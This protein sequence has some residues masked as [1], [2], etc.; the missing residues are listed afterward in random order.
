MDHS[1]STS[2]RKGL[3]VA[4]LVILGLLVAANNGFGFSTEALDR[5][6]AAWSD[7][8][9][10]SMEEEVLSL[11]DYLALEDQ[12]RLTAQAL[13]EV[14]P[15]RAQLNRSQ[16]EQLNGID[17]ISQ[18]VQSEN[19]WP[20]GLQQARDQGQTAAKNVDKAMEK[21]N[22]KRKK[23]STDNDNPSDDSDNQDGDADQAQGNNGRK[24]HR[25]VRRPGGHSKYGYLADFDRALDTMKTELLALNIPHSQW[26]LHKKSGRLD[27]DQRYINTIINHTPSYSEALTVF[28]QRLSALAETEAELDTKALYGELML[29]HIYLRPDHG[30]RVVDLGLRGQQKAYGS[31]ADQ[32]FAARA[33]LALNSADQSSVDGH[34][35]NLPQ[36]LNEQNPIFLEL[37]SALAALLHKYQSQFSGF[38]GSHYKLASAVAFV[39]IINDLASYEEAQPTAT[40]LAASLTDLTTLWDYRSCW[41]MQARGSDRQSICHDQLAPQITPTTQTLIEK[42][43]LR[44]RTSE[45]VKHHSYV[46]QQLFYGASSLHTLLD[47]PVRIHQQTILKGEL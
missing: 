12:K 33:N 43:V 4:A 8:T 21:I 25:R 36:S 18:N 6:L 41:S 11:N 19:S 45:L 29:L 5:A 1:S 34:I 24:P 14:R 42:H 28:N 30:L 35:T 23:S 2:L 27:F 9:P 31:T 46:A 16:L 47:Q 38:D 10:D 3:L 40:R 17:K 20:K 15:H 37:T 26:Q 44:P 32:D 13:N 22:K 39:A 7:F